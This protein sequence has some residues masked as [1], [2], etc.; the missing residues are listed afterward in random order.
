MQLNCVRGLFHGQRLLNELRAACVYNHDVF[1]LR[2][3]DAAERG[4]ALIC[5]RARPIIAVGVEEGRGW[6]RIGI[7]S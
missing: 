7:E 2:V 4:I 5:N 1:L 3:L 6:C